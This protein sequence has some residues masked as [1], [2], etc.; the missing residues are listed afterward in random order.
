MLRRIVG[1]LAE[2]DD[3]ISPF[4]F[5]ALFFIGLFTFSVTDIEKVEEIGRVMM[6]CGLASFCFAAIMFPHSL[7]LAP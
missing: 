1:A 4:Y 3:V 7:R 5:A 2:T 6:Y